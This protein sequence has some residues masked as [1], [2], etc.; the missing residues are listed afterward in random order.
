[1]KLPG[2]PE[3]PMGAGPMPWYM[4]PLAH[5]CRSQGLRCSSAAMGEELPKREPCSC[6]AGMGSLRVWL[7]AACSPPRGMG[8]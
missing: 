8:A 5:H 2:T 7:W 6:P 3:A 1:M 4:Q